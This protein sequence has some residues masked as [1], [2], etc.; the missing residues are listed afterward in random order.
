METNTDKILILISEWREILHSQRQIM[1]LRDLEGRGIG[2]L[3]GGD[4]LAVKFQALQ[5][6]TYKIKQQLFGEYYLDAG[7]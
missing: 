1:K 4:D 2:I 3:V 6:R 7:A 5:K